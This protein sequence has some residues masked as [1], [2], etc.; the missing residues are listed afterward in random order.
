MNRAAPHRPML[1]PQVWD[2]RCERVLHTMS[3]HEDQKVSRERGSSLAK[4]K[5]QASDG[6]HMRVGLDRNTS[7]LHIV[8]PAGARLCL[9]DH[10][11]GR[12]AELVDRKRWRVRAHRSSCGRS[13]RL[14]KLLESKQPRTTLS[15]RCNKKKRPLQTLRSRCQQQSVHNVSRLFGTLVVH[16]PARA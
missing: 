15:E 7:L 14:N 5:Q 11:R 13:V 3:Q 4:K 8:N 2:I 10:S 12:R 1:L 16:D 6:A 9:V